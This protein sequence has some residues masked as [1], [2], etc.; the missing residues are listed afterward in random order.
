MQSA[1]LN[2]SKT[3]TQHKEDATTSLNIDTKHVIIHHMGENS[4]VGTYWERAR[5]LL[6]SNMGRVLM[7]PSSWWEIESRMTH[8]WLQMLRYDNQPLFWLD[9]PLCLC[10]NLR[11][12]QPWRNPAKCAFLI[13]WSFFLDG[14]SGFGGGRT[15]WA[16]RSSVAC[17]RNSL[18]PIWTNIDMNRIVK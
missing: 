16:R 15:E 1:T 3:D 8:R 14:G 17:S 10:N 6:R 2:P 18:N 13:V 7:D 4:Q 11:S 12:Y 5:V 9:L